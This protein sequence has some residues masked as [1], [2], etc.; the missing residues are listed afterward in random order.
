M[1]LGPQFT[2]RSE[3]CLGELRRLT[4]RTEVFS[5][6]ATQLNIK[7]AA[8]AVLRNDL[9]PTRPVD[10][11]LDQT[12]PQGESQLLLG[13]TGFGDNL[14]LVIRHQVDPMDSRIWVGSPIG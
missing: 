4:Q 8:Q 6:A 13:G 2:K 1:L 11:L 7:A 12:F 10:S 5:L 14:V 9:L 3:H